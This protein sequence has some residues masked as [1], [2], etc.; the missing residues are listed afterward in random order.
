MPATAPGVERTSWGGWPEAY[1]LTNGE[2]EL[3]V[4]PAVSRILHYGFAGG[5]NLLW[6]NAALGGRAPSAT[7]WAK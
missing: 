5:T 6:Q 2:A 7:E 3:V 4:V 1:R